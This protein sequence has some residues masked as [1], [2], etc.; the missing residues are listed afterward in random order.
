MITAMWNW[1]KRSYAK[2]YLVESLSN[3][4]HQANREYNKMLEYKLLRGFTDTYSK[5]IIPH[6]CIKCGR[7]WKRSQADIKKFNYTCNS[8]LQN[9]SFKGKRTGEIL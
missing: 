7:F 3:K 4:L 5:N 8:C 2:D 6:R 9:K 1:L